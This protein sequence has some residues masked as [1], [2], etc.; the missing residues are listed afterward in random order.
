MINMNMN[1]KKKLFVAFVSTLMMAVSLTSCNR[2]HSKPLNGVLEFVFKS[3]V[4]EKVNEIAEEFGVD[5]KYE[6]LLDEKQDGV[7]V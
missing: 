2:K 5:E 1:M 6:I 3:E 7:E 4:P